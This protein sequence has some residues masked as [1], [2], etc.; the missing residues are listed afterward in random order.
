MARQLH[1]DRFVEGRDIGG[2][3]L[4]RWIPSEE[5][6]MRRANKALP[7]IIHT[8]RDRYFR[9]DCGD[10]QRVIAKDLHNAKGRLSTVK[11]YAQEVLNALIIHA[12]ILSRRFTLSRK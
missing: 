7:T 11:S 9:K 8:I 10:L 3:G 1:G 12:F 6:G 2:A 5:Q 4:S